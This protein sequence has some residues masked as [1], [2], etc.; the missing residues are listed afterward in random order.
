MAKKT[1]LGSYAAKQCPLRVYMEHDPTEKAVPAAPD[2][3]LQQLFDDGFAFEASIFDEIEQL[4]PNDVVRV[5]GRDDL[6][7]PERRTLTTAAMERGAGVIL[8]AVLPVDTKGRR[9]GEVDV[10]VASPTL[11]PSGKTA[12]R[13]V[14]VKKH[15]CTVNAGS[16]PEPG[17]VHSLQF[18]G[19]DDAAQ[20]LWVPKYNEKD[21]LQLAHYYRMLQA[22]GYA[23]P[24]DEETGAVWAGVIGSERV[25]AWID[26]NEPKFS[27][28]TP[29][30]SGSGARRTMT[31][32]KRGR[33]TKRSALDRYDFEFGF[34]LDLADKAVARTSRRTKRPVEPVQV[35]ECGYCPWAEVCGADLRRRDDVS[36]VGAVG[37]PA[38]AF[39]RFNGVDTVAKLAALDPADPAYADGP[40]TPA[41]LKKQIGQARAEQAG[42]LLLTDGWDDAM[43]PRRD[44]EVDL[45]FESNA[46]G[47]VYL[48]G[49]VV[50]HAQAGWKEH[51]GEYRAFMSLD[52]LDAAGEARLVAQL[53]RWL[54][55][56]RKRAKADGLT[57]GVYGYYSKGTE[58]AALRRIA[59]TK[60]ADGLPTL[61]AVDALVNGDEWIDL[62]PLM[63]SKYL[64]NRLHGLKVVAVHEGFTWRDD[65]PGGLNSIAW[66][67]AA[68]GGDQQ[69][70][71]R[72]KDY[73]ED[74]CRATAWLR[75]I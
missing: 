41:E 65:D 74:D 18:S 72:I 13:P 46:E 35:K 75:R 26:L 32:H 44:V 64:S 30:I 5:P 23:E 53:W 45:D 62:L 3:A 14:D 21:C 2:A 63:Q 59:A 1:M 67:E 47:R 48:W 33:A 36:L 20:L 49:A 27:T 68:A 12:Y 4:Q 37:Y 58:G 22:L 19:A 31:F 17:F 38:W 24:A 6:T 43:L 9:L 55:G 7:F 56:L 61:K 16:E 70:A 50:H 40:L 42:G 39:H 71:Q 11:L 66:Y 8:G 69:A 10:L 54:N 73:N 52:P 51:S 28:V 34:R 60:A 25:V 15:R 57:F 29:Q